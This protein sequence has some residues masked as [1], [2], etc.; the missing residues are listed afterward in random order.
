MLVDA[1][2]ECTDDCCRENLVEQLRALRPK[3]NL[4]ITSRRLD[5]IA[6]YFSA[7]PMLEIN[8]HSTDVR[9]Y[10]TNRIFA[11]G[12]RLSRLIGSDECLAEEIKERVAKTSTNMYGSYALYILVS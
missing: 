1:L 3:I 10:V 5:N 9:A 7:A 11:R 8:A 4:M 12:S 2:D 6:Q